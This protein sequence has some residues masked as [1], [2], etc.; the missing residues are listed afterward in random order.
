MRIKFT[1]LALLFTIGAAAQNLKS[2]SAT[3]RPDSLCYLSIKNAKVYTSSSAGEVKSFLD[4]GLFE[5]KDDKSSLIEWYNLKPDNEKVPAALC[6]TKTKVAAIS[7]DRDQFDKCKTVA[8]LKRMA[9]YFSSNSFSHFAVV[10]SSNDYY[11]RCF[12]VERED[13]KRGLIF[14]TTAGGNAFQI[15]VR[16]E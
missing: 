10:R 11:Q 9:G 12:I 3:M 13:G 4:L 8:D 5:T 6:G 1:F 7:F 15:E 2:F 14:V 16:A